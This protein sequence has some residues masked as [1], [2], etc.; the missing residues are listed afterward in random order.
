MNAVL[1]TGATGF[2]GT[3]TVKYLLNRGYAVHALSS[4]VSGCTEKHENLHLHKVDLLN[5]D[6]RRQVLKSVKPDYLIH[7]AWYVEHGKF[8]TSPINVDWVIASLNLA[9]E[10]AEVGGKRM[11]CAGSCYEY[12][13]RSVSPFSERNTPLLPSSMYGSAKLSL[14]QLLEQ[15]AR[16]LKISFAWGRIFFLF[17][18]HEGPTRLVP[19]VIRSL[20]DGRTAKCSH[21]TQIRDFSD[22]RT[23]A[24]GFV[25]LLESG[26]E[27][28]VN[29]CSGQG[30]EVRELVQMIANVIGREDLIEFNALP[31]PAD[32]PPVIV[33]NNERL[34]KEVCFRPTI[35]LR[36]QLEGT[37]LW[38]RDQK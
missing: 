21:G 27:G 8:W 6:E 38:W 7:L 19:Y 9:R 32:D 12:D 37:V 1:V 16:I 10:F 17:G 20:L 28:P 18:E 11:I 35:E 22:T 29:I 13:L 36:K 15:L 23:V 34:L 25:S 2:V 33:G 14:F 3:P 5:G 24:E 4:K 31:V 26:V 30:I